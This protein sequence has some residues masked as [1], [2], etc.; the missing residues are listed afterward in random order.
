MKSVLSLT[1]KERRAENSSSL[2]RVEDLTKQT[3]PSKD[4]GRR[5]TFNQRRSQGRSNAATGI[6]LNSLKGSWQCFNLH[7]S[8][9]LQRPLA[10]RQP[11]PFSSLSKAAVNASTGAIL[12]TEGHSFKSCQQCKKFFAGNSLWRSMTKIDFIHDLCLAKSSALEA[13]D[14][15]FSVNLLLALIY[16]SFLWQAFLFRIGQK[17]ILNGNWRGAPEDFNNGLGFVLSSPRDEKIEG[18]QNQL[19][20]CWCSCSS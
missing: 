20:R 4:H 1:G 18:Y 5:Q 15:I 11:A 16:G 19:E 6:I 14:T 13:F 9:V 8:Q 12:K 10:M 3:W 2:A 7:Q 17:I